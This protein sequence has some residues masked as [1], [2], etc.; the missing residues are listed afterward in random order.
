VVEIVGDS[1]N[2]V[3]YWNRDFPAELMWPS[4]MTLAI[5]LLFVIFDENL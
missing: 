5:C 3:L 4:T 1:G 2:I